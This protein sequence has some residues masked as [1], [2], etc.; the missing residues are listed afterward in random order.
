MNYLSQYI[1]QLKAF[2]FLGNSGWDYLLTILVFVGAIIIL[3]IFQVVILRKL[4]KLAEKTETEADDLL[5]EIF[6]N[7]RPPFYFLF[8]LFLALRFLNYSD[9]ANKLLF[10]IL[11]AIVVLE[12]IRAIEQVIDF[13]TKKYIEDEEKDNVEKQQAKSMMRIVRTFTVAAMWLIAILVIL[14]NLGINVTSLVASLGIGGIAI[15]LAVQNILSDMFSSFSIF[16]DKPFKV[17]DT[18]VV[19]TDSGTVERIGLKSTRIRTI[20]GEELVVSNKELTTVRIQ[21]LKKMKQRQD[22]FVL[23][24]TY[25]TPKEKL[26]KIPEIIEKIIKNI[27]GAEFKRCYLMEF[28]DSSVNYEVVYVVEP[29]DFAKFVAVKHELNM[30]ILKVFEK[31]NIDLAYP[32]QTIFMK[33]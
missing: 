13:Y 26:I 12:V 27:K 28:A 2:E 33:K 8:A 18:I 4:K 22:K 31:E 6:S 19:G 24:V 10:V 15:A 1:D 32:T 29:P 7:V 17:G 3:K 16:V 25:E 30:E 11:V 23:S 20:R 21:N 5:I 9:F 14:S